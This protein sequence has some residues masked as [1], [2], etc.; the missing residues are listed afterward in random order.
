MSV[1]L[2]QQFID[3]FGQENKNTFFAP[4]R[5]NLIGEHIDYNGGLVMPC[6]ITYGSTLLTAPNKEGIFR[7][8]STNFS[9]VLDIPIKEFYEKMGSS[10]FN[11]PLGVIHNFVKEGKKIQGLDMLFFGNL[12]IGAGLSSSASIEIVTAYAF[13]QLFDAGFSKL[14]LVLL[15]KKVEN[16]FIGVN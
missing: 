12:P 7:F 5:V 8:R 9:E 4:G 11:Y 13:N 16:E 10:W 3:L 15:S 1:Q 2:K 14:E 6:A